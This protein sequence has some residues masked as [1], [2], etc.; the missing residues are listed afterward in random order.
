MCSK[1]PLPSKDEYLPPF[2]VKSHKIAFNTTL[3]VPLSKQSRLWFHQRK[4]SLFR[5]FLFSSKLDHTT[6]SD[7]L[8]VTEA[9]RLKDQFQFAE[10]SFAAWS[11][12]CH[13]QHYLQSKSK[14]V[15][16]SGRDNF[17]LHDMKLAFCNVECSRSIACHLHLNCTQ[18]LNCH[19]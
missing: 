5:P 15:R 6:C 14:N 7:L 3:S 2:P 13:R 10:R 4:L 1:N 16:T 19:T 8:L 11:A 12:Y 9:R 18:L 17:K